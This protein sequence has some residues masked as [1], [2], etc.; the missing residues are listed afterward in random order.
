MVGFHENLG[1]VLIEQKKYSDAEI[2]LKKTIKFRSKS[3]RAQYKLGE[4][5]E[6]TG[7]FDEAKKKI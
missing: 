7:R 2:V 6:K 4:L 5:Y 1:A 3:W